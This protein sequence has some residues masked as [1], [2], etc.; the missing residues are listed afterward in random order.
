[1]QNGNF[2]NFIQLIFPSDPTALIIFSQVKKK[3]KK[4]VSVKS[5]YFVQGLNAT[6]LTQLAYSI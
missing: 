4:Y 2:C 5:K 6:N 1:M 3:K